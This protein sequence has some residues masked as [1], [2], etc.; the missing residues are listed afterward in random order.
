MI[1]YFGEI[2]GQPFMAEKPFICLGSPGNRP[3]HTF[4]THDQLSHFMG[5][6]A[7]AGST[8]QAGRAYEFREGNW[9]L[10]TLPDSI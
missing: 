7:I 5:A 6:Q 4:D 2:D 3:I 9:Q 10:L 1:S 8:I